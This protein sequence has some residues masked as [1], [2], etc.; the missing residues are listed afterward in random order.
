MRSR[1]FTFVEITVVISIVI[2]V[3]GVTIYKFKA[4]RREQAQQLSRVDK[5]SNIRRFLMWFRQDMQSMDEI[6]QFRVLNS[7][8]PDKD[9]RVVEVKFDRFIN[10]FEKQV[11]T[12]LYDFNRRKILRVAEETSSVSTGVTSRKGVGLDNVLNFQMVPYDYDGQRISELSR[13]RDS[14][15]YFEARLLFSDHYGQEKANSIRPFVVK[16]YPKLKSSAN[17][18][19]FNSFYINRRFD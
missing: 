10:E 12:Y 4:E 13:M 2:I 1:G 17:K 18:A 15:Y 14:L 9:S 7:F 3:M 5:Q 16:I 19:G 11:V 8:E 6:I